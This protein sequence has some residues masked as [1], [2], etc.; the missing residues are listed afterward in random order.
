MAG[1]RL[2][3]RVFYLVGFLLFALLAWRGTVIVEGSRAWRNKNPGNLRPGNYT[4]Q[5][6]VGVDPDGYVI[7]GD[8][9]DGFRAMAKDLHT[10]IYTHGYDTIAKIIPV[11]APAADSNNP[12]AYAASVASLSGIGIHDKLSADSIWALVP[13]MARI[14]MGLEWFSLV[15]GDVIGQGVSEGLS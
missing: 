6:Q 5:G 1:G 10:K 3:K 7:F 11:Y 2:D 9:I 13:A 8:L 15:P 12:D 14:E 4:W